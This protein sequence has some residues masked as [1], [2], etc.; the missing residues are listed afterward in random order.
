[1]AHEKHLIR[2]GDPD[3]KNYGEYISAPVTYF[4]KK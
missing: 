1:M 3:G 4:F 2:Y